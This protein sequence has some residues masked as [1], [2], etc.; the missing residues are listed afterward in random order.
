M[1]TK[2]D[3]RFSKLMSKQREISG[4]FLVGVLVEVVGGVLFIIS[5]LSADSL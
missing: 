5:I 3:A 2:H 4:Y 1:T